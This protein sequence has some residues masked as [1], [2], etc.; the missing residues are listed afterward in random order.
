[1]FVTFPVSHLEISALK[2]PA[3]KNTT[4]HPKRI[5]NKWAGKERRARKDARNK[6]RGGL[7]INQK[8]NQ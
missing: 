6:H 2:A 7:K 5:E 1:M 4:H 3:P 8:T